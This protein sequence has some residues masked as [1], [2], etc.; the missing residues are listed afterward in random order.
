M[1][2]IA[3]R[4]VL[5]VAGLMGLVCFADTAEAQSGYQTIN[6][7]RVFTE[8][9]QAGGYATF[10]NDCGSQTL[11]QSQLQNGAVPNNI[12]PCPRYQPP[13]PAPRP[14]YN[15][16]G[17]SSDPNYSAPTPPPPPPPPPKPKMAVNQAMCRE[18][19]GN[20]NTCLARLQTAAAGQG[21]SFQDCIDSYC[22]IS[23]QQGCNLP[24][25]CRY[26]VSSNDDQPVRCQVGYHLYFRG[27]GSK[28]VCQPNAAGDPGPGSGPDQSTITG[29]LN[30]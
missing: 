25:A 7:T 29:P 20:T 6:G 3:R 17:A 12:I 13:P 2:C 27:Y 14:N 19:A 1:T 28:P 18:L 9:N 15:S 22:K 23:A 21:K 10:S 16:S 11:T 24:N 5:A 8:I 4:L 26:G 30:H